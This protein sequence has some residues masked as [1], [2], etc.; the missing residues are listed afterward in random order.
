MC[1]GAGAAL[2]PGR[3][4]RN[5]PGAA[6]APPPGSGLAAALGP[7]RSRPGPLRA[8]GRAAP[9][10]RPWE[11]EAAAAAAPALPR[12]ARPGPAPAPPAPAPP[13][14]RA[15]Q[16]RGGLREERRFRGAGTERGPGEVGAGP[17]LRPQRRAVSGAG[18]ESSGSGDP[19]PLGAER[20][21]DSWR[22]ASGLG[23]SVGTPREPKGSN[24]RY[25]GRLQVSRD[26]SLELGALL[27]C[28]WASSS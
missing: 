16:R 21:R 8:R 1:G 15:A 5:P 6:S 2:G 9:R 13:P 11:T 12:A 14:G 20:D 7:R 3:K 22:P 19:Q 25:P 4:P 17:L 26:H 10:E 27:G 23:C 28:S 24:P 18:S